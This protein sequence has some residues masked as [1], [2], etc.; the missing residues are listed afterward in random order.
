MGCSDGGVLVEDGFCGKFTRLA[1]KIKLNLEKKIQF[2]TFII[3]LAIV[4]VLPC[5]RVFEIHF[6]HFDLTFR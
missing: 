2:H 1:L 5:D 3:D 4:S 6:H